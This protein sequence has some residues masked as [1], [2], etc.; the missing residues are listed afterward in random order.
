MKRTGKQGQTAALLFLLCTL[1]LLILAGVLAQG[2]AYHL[3]LAV[4]V[5][6]ISPTITGAEVKS[7]SATQRGSASS[8]ALNSSRKSYL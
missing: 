7:I 5:E 1:A 2:R 4:D 3:T 6:R 8:G